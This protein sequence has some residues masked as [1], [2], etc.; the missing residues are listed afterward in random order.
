MTPREKAVTTKATTS[1]ETT[2]SVTEAEA[3]T[4]AAGGG[5]G[6]DD[7][8]TAERMG[9]DGRVLSRGWTEPRGAERGR[10]RWR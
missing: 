7:R 9:R 4:A 3:A 1:A 8:G 6:V 10:C 5:G 2:S